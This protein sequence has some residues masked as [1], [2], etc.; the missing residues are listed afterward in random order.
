MKKAIRKIWKQ[1]CRR[2]LNMVVG[3]KV[4]AIRILNLDLLEQKLCLY[5]L[6]YVNVSYIH[7]QYDLCRI[8]LS[9]M[10]IFSFVFWNFG[11]ATYNLKQYLAYE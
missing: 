4:N 10:F 3:A 7:Y 6:V 5:L 11:Y 9:Y 2:A 8:F 1:T